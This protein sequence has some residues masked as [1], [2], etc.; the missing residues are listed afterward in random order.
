MT[1]PGYTAEV[2]LFR[3]TQAYR[4]SVASGGST[5]RIH[6]A[7]FPLTVRSSPVFT[8]YVVLCCEKCWLENQKCYWRWPYGAGD[9]VCVD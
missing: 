3:S 2:T 7:L 8:V 4:L 1:L 5:E 9:C 6:P